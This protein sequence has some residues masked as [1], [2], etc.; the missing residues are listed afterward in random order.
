MVASVAVNK[1]VFRAHIIFSIIAHLLLLVQ[2][3]WMPV[4]IKSDDNWLGWKSVASKLEQIQNQN[5]NRFVF[6]DNSY[7]VSAVLNFYSQEHIYAGNIIGKFAYQFALDDNNLSHL[8]GK[9][10]IYVT[11]ERYRRK[12]LKVTTIEQMLGEYFSS[13]ALI[14]SVEIKNRCGS[15]HRKF[16]F[17][18]CKEYN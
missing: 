2:L 15:V 12:N 9:D 13:S 4:K 17:Y 7:K 1:K 14:D 3:I 6:S 18:E 5:P 16:Y 10:A 11:S 8:H